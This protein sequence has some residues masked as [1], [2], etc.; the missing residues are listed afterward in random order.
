MNLS[1]GSIPVSI[2]YLFLTGA[3]LTADAQEYQAAWNIVPITDVAIETGLRAALPAPPY[4][5][6][7]SEEASFVKAFRRSPRRINGGELR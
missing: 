3:G 7:A 1:T 2:S 5:L 4:V 6:R